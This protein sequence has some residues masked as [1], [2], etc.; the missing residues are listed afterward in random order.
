MS[1]YR[2]NIIGTVKQMIIADNSKFQI[3]LVMRH[4]LRTTEIGQQ[5]N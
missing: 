2:L 4:L 1:N 5:P 3:C